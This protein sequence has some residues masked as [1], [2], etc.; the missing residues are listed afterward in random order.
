MAQLTS[1]SPLFCQIL[2][3]FATKEMTAL[4]KIRTPDLLHMKPACYR[5]AMVTSCVEGLKDGFMNHFKYVL[6]STFLSEIN[7]AISY[8][9]YL[10]NTLSI[11]DCSH[12]IKSQC[13]WAFSKTDPNS[14]CHTHQ[15]YDNR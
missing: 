7:K 15:N 1:R 6:V 8:F 4:P 5:S 2:K 12:M 9:I 10:D 3:C 13:S 14:K 11:I